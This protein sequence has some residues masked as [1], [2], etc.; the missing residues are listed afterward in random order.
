[1]VV[2]LIHVLLISKCVCGGGGVITQCM[3]D[4]YILSNFIDLAALLIHNLIK[5]SDNWYFIQYM[6]KIFHT[7]YV[8]Y[9]LNPCNLCA[10]KLNNPTKKHK[11][12]LTHKRG[13]PY[14]CYI[15]N[16]TNFEI[17]NLNIHS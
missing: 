5:T 17:Y 3:D 8:N 6:I 7:I 9:I 4:P 11:H 15:C 2:A 16:E 10:K 12:E 14:R 1:M 13:Q